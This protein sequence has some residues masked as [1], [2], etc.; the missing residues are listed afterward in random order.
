MKNET[1]QKEPNER[2]ENEEW[3]NNRKEMLEEEVWKAN[4]DVI[5][6]QR[7]LNKAEKK[8]DDFIAEYK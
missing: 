8:L 2:M 4:Q 1:T 7:A 5:S 6:A 3:V